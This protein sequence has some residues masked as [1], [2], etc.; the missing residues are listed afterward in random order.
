[1]SDGTETTQTLIFSETYPPSL[2][3]STSAGRSCRMGSASAHPSGAV[4][5]T[6]Y[7]TV[8]GGSQLK[9]VAT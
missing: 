5:M 8:Q 4:S 6:L 2:F 9:L 7:R 1:M 3:G